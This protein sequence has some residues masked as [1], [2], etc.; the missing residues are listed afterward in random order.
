MAFWD[1]YGDLHVEFETVLF[2]L[3]SLWLQPHAMR[4]SQK[5]H[6]RATVMSMP[7]SKAM[8]QVTMKEKHLSRHDDQMSNNLRENMGVPIALLRQNHLPHQLQPSHD[9]RRQCRLATG[10]H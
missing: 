3:G 2:G 8:P 9:A 1:V 5:D 7:S 6:G 4:F 10:L